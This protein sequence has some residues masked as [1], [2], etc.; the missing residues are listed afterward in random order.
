M[1][2][3]GLIHRNSYL[4]RK[5]IQFHDALKI[6][7]KQH[8]GSH[9]RAQ[10]PLLT[11]PISFMKMDSGGEVRLWILHILPLHLGFLLTV[12]SEM[13]TAWRDSGRHTKGEA[14]KK[15]S[16]ITKAFLLAS[17]RSLAQQCHSCSW[18]CCQVQN[19]W[20]KLNRWGNEVNWFPAP[21]MQGGFHCKVFLASVPVKLLSVMLLLLLGANSLQGKAPF[22]VPNNVFHQYLEL[23]RQ[24]AFS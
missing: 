17:T 6:Q 16:S 10:L 22:P 18:I 1:S 7:D 21:R 5:W 12:S 11:L 24:V 23:C 2:L 19:C 13:C 20:Q 14:F 15:Y 3:A 4:W 8:G 9:V